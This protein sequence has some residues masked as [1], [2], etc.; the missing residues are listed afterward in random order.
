MK[1]NKTKNTHPQT[2]KTNL[3]K[4]A[5][6]H[7]HTQNKAK[8]GSSLCWPEH[9]ACPGVWLIYSVMLLAKTYIIFPSGC[10]LQLLG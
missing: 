9:G 1:I 7:K 3:K 2:T 6:T 4:K 10:Q 8:L 5:P